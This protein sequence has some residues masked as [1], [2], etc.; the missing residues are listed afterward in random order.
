MCDRCNDDTPATWTYLQ[1]LPSDDKHTPLKFGLCDRHAQ[2]HRDGLR[3]D[4]C[5]AYRV[6]T[7]QPA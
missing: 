5:L 2:T 3:A 1:P 7:P 6:I 4:G